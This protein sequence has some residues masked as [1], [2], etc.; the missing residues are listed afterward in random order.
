MQATLPVKLRKLGIR[1]VT[2]LAL[3]TFLASVN[4]AVDLIGTILFPLFCDDEIIYFEE[5]TNAWLNET[6]RIFLSDLRSESALP[7][8]QL[9]TLLD[10]NSPTVAISSRLGINICKPYTCACEKAVDSSGV[11]GLSCNKSAEKNSMHPALNGIMKRPLLFTSILEPTGLMQDDGKRPD[12]MTIISWKNGRA[13]VWDD[14]CVN[15]L[16]T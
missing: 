10:K 4:S 13:L 9:G 15:V 12:G 16:A 6:N 8:F 11:H 1:S 5:A 7:S 2:D 14:I 3:P